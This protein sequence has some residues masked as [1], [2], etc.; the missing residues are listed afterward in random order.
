MEYPKVLIAIPVYK[1][2][3]LVI[4]A[5]ESALNQKTDFSVEILLVIDGCPFPETFEVA[6]DFQFTYKD[7]I[8]YIVRKNGGLSAARNTAIN[9]LLQRPSLEALYFLDA[10]NRLQ[11]T[12]TQTAFTT[13]IREMSD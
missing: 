9:Y 4:E 6:R 1:H 13:L 3:A 7:K 8:H 5:L 2:S 10:D 11:P 12:S